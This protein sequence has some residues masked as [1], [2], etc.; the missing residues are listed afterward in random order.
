[1]PY[2]MIKPAPVEFDSCTRVMIVHTL[3]EPRTNVY[4]LWLVCRESVT[5]HY[6]T[7][8]RNARSKRFL[9]C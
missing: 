9:M 7:P 6:I 3:I 1:M 5:F 2:D 8:V 4:G